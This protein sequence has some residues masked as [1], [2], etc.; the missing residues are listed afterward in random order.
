MSSA[1][2]YGFVELGLLPGLRNLAISLEMQRLGPL[3]A[4]NKQSKPL[5]RFFYSVL[6]F[7]SRYR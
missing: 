5:S 6:F 4:K 1:Y 7:R 3:D 2:I